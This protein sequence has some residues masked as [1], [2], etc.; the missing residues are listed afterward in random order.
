MASTP[1]YDMTKFTLIYSGSQRLRYLSLSVCLL[2]QLARLPF[3]AES[4]FTA[5]QSRKSVVRLVQTLKPP[6]GT[7][8][9]RTRSSASTL[10]VSSANEQ[11]PSTPASA[12]RAGAGL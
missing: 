5:S 6:R 3:T 2:A 8:C 10:T 4:N 1:F 9:P 12:S 11:I 7:A